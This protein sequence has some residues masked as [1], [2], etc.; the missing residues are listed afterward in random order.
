VSKRPTI[1]IGADP[2]FFLE[3]NGN[4]KSAIGRIGGVKEAPRPLGRD[5]FAVQE[6]NVAVEFNIPP[7]ITMESFIESI[8]WSMK[9]ISEE[10]SV[11]GYKPSK[12][13][14]ALFPPAELSDP[15]ALQFG[16]DP[17]FNAW[18]GGRRNPKP[19]AKSERLRSCGGHVHVGYPSD[20]PID[21]LRLIQLMDLYLGVPSVIMDADQGRRELYGKAG[22]Y[23]EQPYGVEYRTLSNF[24]LHDIKYQRWVYE[25]TQRAVDMALGFG[26]PSG[27]LHQVG[28]TWVQKPDAFDVFMESRDLCD[29]IQHT[30]NMGDID[31]AQVLIAHHDLSIV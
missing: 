30:I 7:A 9:R 19:R 3:Q 24:W 6:D 5:G 29:E 2:E 21:R 4:L 15:R 13:A 17:D 10:V 1:T 26:P 8:E 25:Q 16:C 23:R 14:S 28:S 11:F 18:H 22:A 31:R 20:T 27:E 12:L